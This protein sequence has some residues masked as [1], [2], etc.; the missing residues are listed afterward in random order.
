ML[1]KE[2]EGIKVIRESAFHVCHVI[3]ADSTSCAVANFNV[4]TIRLLRDH[5]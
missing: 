1:G 4:R 2:N 5:H 3:G